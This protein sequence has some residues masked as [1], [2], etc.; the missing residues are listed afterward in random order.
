MNVYGA[1]YSGTC[2][3]SRNIKVIQSTAGTQMYRTILLLSHSGTLIPFW[4]A[5][6]YGAILARYT[7]AT[8]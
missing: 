4:H 5:N 3:V 8:N 7:L 1:I 2:S 6:V